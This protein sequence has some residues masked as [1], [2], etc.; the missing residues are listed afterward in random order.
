M[1]IAIAIK[2]CHRYADR[3]YAC[4]A[5]WI[6]KLDCDWF[7]VLGRDSNGS[8]LDVPNALNCDVADEFGRM[9]PK[10]WC[11][12]KYA[13]EENVQ[14][15]FICDDD[16]YVCVPRLNA[17]GMSFQDYVGFVRPAGFD[18][19][20]I[21]GSGYWLSAKAMEHVVAAQSVMRPGVIDDGAVGL[22]LDGKVA[23]VHD[24]RYEP[25]PD[26]TRITKENALIT[27]HKCL[28]GVM[29][30]VHADWMKSCTI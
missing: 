21:Q 3:R 13:L 16:T 4:E 7:F 6:P 24:R 10:V 18:V 25:G 19:P 15:L 5:T 17:C 23:L 12:C 28:P 11:A 27:T 14:R 26:P 9:A 1:K 22:A 29:Q 30:Q 8:V 20:Y 2:S